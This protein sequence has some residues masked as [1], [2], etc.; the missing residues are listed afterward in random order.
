MTADC[1]VLLVS[2]ELLKNAS[3]AIPIVFGVVL[4]SGISARNTDP[5]TWK[6][7]VRQAVISSWPMFCF[8]ALVPTPWVHTTTLGIFNVLFS[9]LV[10]CARDS[11]AN[12]GPPG[13]HIERE[14]NI[15]F[16]FSILGTLGLLFI[17]E[18]LRAPPQAEKF[19]ASESPLTVQFVLEL[20]RNVAKSL[21]LLGSMAG[22]SILTLALNPESHRLFYA[23]HVAKKAWANYT[24]WDAARAGVLDNFMGIIVIAFCALFTLSWETY[25]CI[26]LITSLI[27]VIVNIGTGDGEDRSHVETNCLF[28][29]NGFVGLVR[30]L[31]FLKAA[32]H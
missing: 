22:A 5:S 13:L 27:P 1:L 3:K 6:I 26:S 25:F 9:I 20:S 7:A 12:Y 19:L 8:C 16:V 30:L 11:S 23:P 21:P 10:G 17:A 29:L 14:L 32:F 4:A 24:M 31:F 15:L 28:W 18:F 2:L